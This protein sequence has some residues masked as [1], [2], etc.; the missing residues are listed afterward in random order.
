MARFVTSSSSSEIT[1]ATR[2]SPEPAS[3]EQA[4]V[5]ADRKSE[6]ILRRYEAKIQSGDYTDA[7]YDNYRREML[8]VMDDF[9]QYCINRLRRPE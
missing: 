1:H 7:D 3:I 4:K 6:E 2:R 8:Q 5:E 9:T